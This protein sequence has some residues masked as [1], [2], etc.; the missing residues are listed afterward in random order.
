MLISHPEVLVC[1]QT[2]LVLP[3]TAP[4]LTF[5]LEKKTLKKLNYSKQHDMNSEEAK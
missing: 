5:K 4:E 1:K 3:K 2:L